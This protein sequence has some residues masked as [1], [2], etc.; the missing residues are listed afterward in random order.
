MQQ[1]SDAL[2]RFSRTCAARSTTFLY[3]CFSHFCRLKSSTIGPVWHETDFRPVLLPFVSV[4]LSKLGF[5]E[6]ACQRHREGNSTVSALLE[7]L[8]ILGECAAVEPSIV[9]ISLIFAYFFTR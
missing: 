1:S 8:F 6:L 5:Q 3:R 9:F 4:Q 7:S 2:L